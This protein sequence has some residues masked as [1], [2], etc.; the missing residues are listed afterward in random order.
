M[1]DYTADD[2]LK[3]IEHLGLPGLC[4]EEEC[5]FRERWDEYYSARNKDVTMTTWTIYAQALPYMCG[6]PERIALALS[7][8]RDNLFAKR[9]EGNDLREKIKEGTEAGISMEKIL[10]HYEAIKY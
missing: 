10:E 3:L 7:K 1:N 6:D 5:K 8:E 4:K 9:L 2:G